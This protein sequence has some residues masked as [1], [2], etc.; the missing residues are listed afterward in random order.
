VTE[1][2]DEI[3]RFLD[4]VLGTFT[5]SG[6]EWALLRGRSEMATGRD[7][8]LLV[9]AAH[10]SVA[11]EII[12]ELG[13]VQLPQRR[14]PWHKMYVFDVPHSAATL[15]VDIVDR[16]IYSQE[17][18]IASELEQGC[19]ER[20]VDDG[21]LFLLSSTD[22]FWTILLHC[23]LD[24]RKV[25]EQRADELLARVGDLDRP[26][27]GEAF[28]ATLCPPGWSPER[29]IDCVVRRDWEPL[30]RLGSQIL[31]LRLAETSPLN[32]TASV[33]AALH[34]GRRSRVD[35]A[36][37]R[38]SNAA[39]GAAYRKV[40]RGLGLGVVPHVF[41]LVEEAQIDTT[42]IELR[43]RP[44]AC[45]VVLVIEDHQLPRLLPLMVGHYRR[46][47]GRWRRLTAGGLESVVLIERSELPLAERRD[48]EGQP[49]SLPLPNRPHCRMAL[50]SP[51]AADTTRRGRRTGG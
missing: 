44:R 12:V 40:W 27:P 23:V 24:K 34:G 33:P 8:D 17:L 5:G 45:D 39:T 18:Q 13:G 41:D 14:Y 11:D 47:A 46:G 35:K 4:Q 38:I 37:R 43:R 30:G 42:V 51:V 28:F 19:L 6:V 20:R 50:S 36:K 48:G 9:Q 15:K 31:A 26:S 16:L 25:K 49:P 2:N 29:A 32:R 10:L 7:V 22:A 3:R 1:D 21:G